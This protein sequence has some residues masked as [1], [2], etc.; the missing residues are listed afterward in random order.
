[1]NDVLIFPHKL[2]RMERKHFEGLCRSAVLCSSELLKDSDFDWI[3]HR[4]LLEFM[5]TQIK[6]MDAFQPEQAQR[7][8]AFLN[9]TGPDETVL[10]CCDSGVSRSSALAAAFIRSRNGDEMEIWENPRFR[11]NPLVYR[12]LCESF[13]IKVTEREIEIRLSINENA[14]RIALQ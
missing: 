5:D 4:L 11:P 2:V 8:A 9:E 1:M 7:T 13:G 12:L 10:F 14:F 6:R 3:P